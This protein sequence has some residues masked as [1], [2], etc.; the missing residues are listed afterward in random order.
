[1]VAPLL[2]GVWKSG[3]PPLVAR[4]DA[5]FHEVGVFGQPPKDRE[6]LQ[7]QVV[8]WYGLGVRFFGG[9]SNT[10]IGHMCAV[11]EALD[12]VNHGGKPPC[13]QRRP[14]QK[15]SLGAQFRIWSSQTTCI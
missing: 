5:E 15:H 7:S 10:G 6:K 9:C 2:S 11:V 14:R 12:T 13:S 1:M 3:R 4:P 8:E